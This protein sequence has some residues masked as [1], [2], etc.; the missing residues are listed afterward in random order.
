MASA[1][2][3]TF[4]KRHN[5]TKQPTG[6]SSYTITLKD[7]C[8]VSNPT[9]SLKWP[10][11][12]SPTAFNMCYIPSFG[13]YYWIDNWTFADRQWTASCSVDV[14]ASFKTD[15][16][17]TTRYILRSASDY[18]P[19]APEN[20]YMPIMPCEVLQ[21]GLTE[22]MILATKFDY[23]RFVVGIC[24]QGNTFNAGGTGYVVCTGAQLQ[25]IYDACFTQSVNLWAS[26]TSLGVGYGETMARF[27]ENLQKSIA[28]PSQFINSIT[29]VPFVPATSG[30]TTV[31]LGNIDTNITCACLSDP[32][33]MITFS[34]SL[35]TFADRPASPDDWM[36]ME[37]F[38]E[39]Y[40][41][42]P[43]FPDI[44]VPG[45]IFIDGGQISGWVYVDVTNGEANMRLN[46]ILGAPFHTATAM[47]GIPIQ[48]S[49]SSVNYAG[50]ISNGLGTIGSI[51]GVVSGNAGAI[52][53]LA[54]GVA[55]F[56]SSLQPKATGGGYG[57]GL[58][59]FKD[60]HT[61]ITYCYPLPEMDPTEYGK[62]LL[63][64]KTISS[65]SGF[66]QCADGELDT[67][68]RPA[69]YQ[70]IKAFLTG[71]FFYE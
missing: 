69:E 8:S 43:P 57:G 71:G 28:N 51:V 45:E 37:P 66:V 61:L 20:K 18:D 16:G 65:L 2:F 50:A 30:S 58:G 64:T 60:V 4:S 15:I 62:P 26:Q 38:V 63:Q 21:H 1:T 52:G 70:A 49:G 19:H 14:L 41:H 6:G 32:V 68:A 11:T 36:L 48:L 42:W 29:W 47:L 40:I 67:S 9:I 27:G 5:S 55:G 31:R 44:K 10:G 34:V 3:Y 59:A 23:G 35:P 7:A 46:N 13:R 24:G 17:G 22:S 54:S 39:Y 33:T 53:G 25:Q 56:A 12:G